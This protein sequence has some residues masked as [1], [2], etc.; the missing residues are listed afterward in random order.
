MTEKTELT[1]EQKEIIKEINDQLELAKGKIKEYYASLPPTDPD[2]PEKGKRELILYIKDKHVN[3]W[4]KQTED[5]EGDVIEMRV[6][7]T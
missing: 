6:V 4:R 5:I 7:S 1:T 2:H 3:P